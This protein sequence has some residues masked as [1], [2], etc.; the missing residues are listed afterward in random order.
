MNALVKTAVAV[1]LVLALGL[2]SASSL[3][4][5]VGAP[6]GGAS[7]EGSGV[8]ERVPLVRSGGLLVGRPTQSVV[9]MVVIDAPDVGADHLLMREIRM[10]DGRHSVLFTAPSPLA[11]QVRRTSLYVKEDGRKWRVLESVDGQTL[12]HDAHPVAVARGEVGGAGDDVLNPLLGFAVNGLGP[13][14]LVDEGFVV[15][16]PDGAQTARSL[17]GL[18]PVRAILYIGATVLLL[19]LGRMVS[20]WAHRRDRHVC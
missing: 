11:S 8:R 17:L 20:L 13:Y 16:A 19:M 10:P 2:A 18:E 4:V 1:I 7:A 9:Q 6:S 5:I 14:W 3:G 12:S 15:S